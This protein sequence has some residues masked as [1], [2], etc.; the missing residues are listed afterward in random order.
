MSEKEE[1]VAKLK[2]IV[3]DLGASSVPRHE[4]CG[5]LACLSERMPYNSVRSLEKSLKS[6]RTATVDWRQFGNGAV[7]FWNSIPTGRDLHVENETLLPN[8][9]G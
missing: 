4:S 1:I 5:V 7:S 9:A 2:E 3:G 6:W 8:H